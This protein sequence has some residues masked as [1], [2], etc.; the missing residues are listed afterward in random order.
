MSSDAA[1]ERCCTLCEQP[2]HSGQMIE[3]VKCHNRYHN[4]CAGG[5]DGTSATSSP[6]YCDLCRP[7]DPAPSVSISSAASTTASA[8]E[9]RLQLQMQ[10]LAEEKLLQERLMAEREKAERE[11]LRLERERNEKAIADKIELEKVFITRKYDLLLAQVDEGDDNRSVRSRRSSLKSAQRVR[12]WIDNQQVTLNTKSGECISTGFTSQQSSSANQQDGTAVH[13][14]NP[15]EPPKTIAANDINVPENQA[16]AATV[17]SGWMDMI[18]PFSSMN[19]GPTT[20]APALLPTCQSTPFVAPTTT[21]PQA[22][23][24]DDVELAQE[25]QHNRTYSVRIDPANTALEVEPSLYVGSAPVSTPR[26]QV[27]IADTNVGSRARGDVFSPSTSISNR[28]RQFYDANVAVSVSSLVGDTGSNQFRAMRDIVTIPSVTQT[29]QNPIRT[30]HSSSAAMLSVSSYQDPIFSLSMGSSAPQFPPLSNVQSIA[31]NVAG[32]S[33]ARASHAIGVPTA[34]NPGVSDRTVYSS[35]FRSDCF[36]SGAISAPGIN[37][38]VDHLRHP[39]HLAPVVSSASVH[40][41]GMN[42]PSG[43]FP[44]AGNSTPMHSYFNPPF[45]QREI[46]GAAHPVSSSS[47]DA[48]LLNA[49]TAQQLAARHVVPKELPAFSGNPAEWPLFWSS[50][51]TSTRICGYSDSENLMRLQRCLK[52]EARKAVSCFLLHPLNVPEILRTLALYTDDQRPSL[53]HC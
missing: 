28:N 13:N 52:G 19:L 49:P 25:D 36:N 4:S 15:F 18:S 38:R 33:S 12:I 35:Q 23:Q 42:A 40:P 24:P 21:H 46:I 20:S 8:R 48:Q 6:Y 50:Y 29:N 7:R 27:R 11:M 53:G 10:Q 14:L 22:S 16:V 47:F 32:P 51:E 44:S 31:S 34:V 3:C 5:E 2:T 45:Q 1:A 17:T 41:A 30:V 9:A 43:V 37:S 26:R 39:T